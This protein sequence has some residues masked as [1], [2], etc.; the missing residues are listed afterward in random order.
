MPPLLGAPLARALEL[1]AGA[2]D[3][4]GI[5]I[6]IFGFAV[7]LTKLVA[8]LTK[9]VGLRVGVDDLH[10]A[11]R[12]LATYILTALEFMIASDIIHS[13]ITRN[14]GDLYFVALLVAIRTAISYFLT[15]EIRELRGVPAP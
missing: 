9:S 3:L 11:R 6:L 4:I 13:A 14:V 15:R 1:I 8:E 10:A 12:T 2:I 7:A 5:A